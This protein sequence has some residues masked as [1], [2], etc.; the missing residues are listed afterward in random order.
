MPLWSKTKSKHFKQY[1]KCINIYLKLITTQ[2]AKPSQPYVSFTIEGN[3]VN[4]DSRK[5]FTIDSMITDNGQES[6]MLL[7][8]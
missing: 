3:G 6:A 8:M 5:I 1:T 2:K 7:E 4:L